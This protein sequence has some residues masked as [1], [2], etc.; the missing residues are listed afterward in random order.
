MIVLRCVRDELNWS[1]A[2]EIPE[3]MFDSAHCSQVKPEEVPHVSVNALRA[4]RVLVTSDAD[5]IELPAVQAQHSPSDSGGADADDIPIQDAAGPVVYSATTTTE[6][7]TGGPS[8]GA[9]PI[10][11][12]D[13]RAPRK[14]HWC[15]GTSGGER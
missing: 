7:S 6:S 1:A 14:E 5:R 3:W 15:P 4:L 13:E 11:A 2:L 8:A 9:S 10:G 12:D